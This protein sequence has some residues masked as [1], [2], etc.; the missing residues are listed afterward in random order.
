MALHI[1]EKSKTKSFPN[2]FP[3]LLRCS[4]RISRVSYLRKD[5]LPFHDRKILPPSEAS[6]FDGSV[7][8]IERR[9]SS[10]GI[11]MKR[12]ERNSSTCPRIFRERRK[13][14]A[15]I[16]YEVISFF[17][18][19]PLLPFVLYLPLSFTIFSFTPFRERT[20][21]GATVSQKT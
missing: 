6:L 3:A 21:I 8:L 17:S 4:N 10:N 16:L 13:V 19:N 20:K 18:P 11:T 15:K 7:Q 14:A 12:R 5:M 9:V 1:V 2:V